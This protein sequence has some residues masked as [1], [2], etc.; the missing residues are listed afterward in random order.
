MIREGKNTIQRTFMELV[1]LLQKQGV[2]ENVKAV[3][4]KIV[5]SALPALIN[6]NLEVRIP[7]SKHASI[8]CAHG[9]TPLERESNLAQPL[10]LP[11]Q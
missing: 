10:W 3:I 6:Q 8:E 1:A 7:K 4:E 9:K 5:A 11:H 2:V